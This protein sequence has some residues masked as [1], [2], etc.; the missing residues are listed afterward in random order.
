MDR[1]EKHCH[2]LINLPKLSKTQQKKLIESLTTDQVKF[3]VELA[4]NLLFNDI[5]KLN[6]ETKKKNKK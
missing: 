3:V 1:I 5:P 4:A 2:L 6:S